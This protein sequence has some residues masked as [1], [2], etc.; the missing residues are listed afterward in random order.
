[1]Y[2][3]PYNQRIRDE[4]LQLDQAYIT[5]GRETNTTEYPFLK[6]PLAPLIEGQDLHTLA[7]AQ[8]RSGLA[9]A[10]D[11]L[12]GGSAVINPEY[13]A[14]LEGDGV[15]S[16]GDGMSGGYMGLGER[17]PIPEMYNRGNAPQLQGLGQHENM[18][19][20]KPEDF[21]KEHKKLTKML[22]KT[23]AILS[24]E[25]E[26]QKQELK[27][28][29]KKM[30]GGFWQFLLPIVAPTAIKAVRDITGLG[31][32]EKEMVLDSQRKAGEGRPDISL[33]GGNIGLAQSQA[34]IDY[35]KKLRGG[36]AYK[37]I[38]SG[39]GVEVPKGGMK[40]QLNMIHK[41]A[42]DPHKLPALQAVVE[43][44]EPH[45]QGAGWFDK[46][47]KTLGLDVAYEKLKKGAKNIYQ[48]GK[49]IAKKRGKEL[50]ESLGE[51]AQDALIDLVS[52]KKVDVKKNLEELK[53]K[54][55]RKGIESLVDLK[56]GIIEETK[57][58]NPRRREREEHIKFELDPQ[59]EAEEEKIE[60]ERRRR[61]R[62][63]PKKGGSLMLDGLISA[64]KFANSETGQKLKDILMNMKKRGGNIDGGSFL[65]S[66][67]K[68]EQFA[69]SQA[70]QDILSS[71]KDMFKGRGMEGG[72]IN[73][74]LL[75]LG[76]LSPD[77]LEK[78]MSGMLKKSKGG[79][80]KESREEPD[81]DSQMKNEDGLTE[82]SQ[83]KG[84][85]GTG[86]KQ[87]RGALIKKLMKEKGM[88]LG[89]ASKYIKQHNLL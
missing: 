72:I 42:Q 17:P 2:N 46:L 48:T 85:I 60:Q 84:V 55:K 11:D 61:G 25:S 12:R 6:D 34:S 7:I 78:M 9:K 5:H 1:M 63:R 39:L 70:G 8:A 20:M 18:I 27:A 16:Y 50:M 10:K 47:K 41:L 64:Q 37:E 30:K 19:E 44:L 23:S 62:G 36:Q 14:S 57:N 59:E 28:R 31:M 33:H 38:I 54:A 32:V 26:E 89:E 80:Y 83:M 81:Y 77:V 71:L 4:M 69:N 21:K 43:S 15:K 82:Q 75:E 49:D 35:F 53:K 86:K 45:L 76:R 73:T 22:D 79:A 51:Q 67:G 65:G 52:G 74:K 29:S 66:L 40:A 13:M 24:D 58:L 87:A 3:T 68:A 56:E 88:K